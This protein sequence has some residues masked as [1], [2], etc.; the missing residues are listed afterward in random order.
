MLF[1]ALLLLSGVAGQS[2]PADGSS[3]G[4]LLRPAGGGEVAAALQVGRRGGAAVSVGEPLTWDQW[5][6]MDFVA[7]VRTNGRFRVC[8]GVACHECV[9][10][11]PPRAGGRNKCTAARR[12]FRA[13]PPPS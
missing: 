11:V 7:K 5:A 9:I 3:R 13:L 12:R 1:V 2:A 10:H 4:G 8:T 6:S